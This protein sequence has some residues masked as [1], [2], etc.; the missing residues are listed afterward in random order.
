MARCNGIYGMLGQHPPKIRIFPLD[1][2]YIC[3]FFALDTP[4]II[5]YIVIMML[6]TKAIAKTIP[7]LYSQ[8]GKGRQ[9]VARAKFFTPWANWTWYATEM[10]I[11]QDRC[12]GLV[13]SP[14]CPTGELGYFSL[15]ELATITGPAGLRIERD[16]YFTPAPLDTLA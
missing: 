8:D 16:R 14:Q 7:P 2:F 1:T 10:D 4:L 5:R 12:F 15:R 3:L 9:A 6:M 11:D 13:V